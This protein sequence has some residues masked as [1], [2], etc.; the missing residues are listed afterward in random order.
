MEFL[1]ECLYMVKFSKDYKDV[2]TFIEKFADL[3]IIMVKQQHLEEMYLQEKKIDLD[4]K[5]FNLLINLRKYIINSIKFIPVIEKKNES[6]V[7]KCFANLVSKL[8]LRLESSAFKLNQKFI[9]HSLDLLLS[10]NDHIKRTGK[11]NP[12]ILITL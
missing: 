11:M 4:L 3:Y 12:W 8:L 10:Y 9:D 6:Q 5:K 2:I 7:I 1:L